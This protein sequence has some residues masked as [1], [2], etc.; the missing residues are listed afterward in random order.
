MNWRDYITSDPQICH[1]K[2]IIKGT[3]IMVS[4]I[5]D[6]LAAGLS[7]EEILQSYPSLKREDISAAIAYAAEL[8]SERVISTE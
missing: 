6:N 3:R 1:G 7:A 2:A 5:L 8:A 4:V